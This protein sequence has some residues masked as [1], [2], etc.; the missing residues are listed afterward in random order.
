MAKQPEDTKTPD[1]LAA[2]K[3]RGRPATGSAKTAAERKREQR[4][5]DR[6]KVWGDAAI[7]GNDQISS[8]TMDGLLE[9]IRETTAKGLDALLAPLLAEVMHRAQ[10]NKRDKA[11]TEG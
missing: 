5:R 4:I 1:M 10:T 6:E 2:Q 3:K 7:T 11:S 8:L 9:A